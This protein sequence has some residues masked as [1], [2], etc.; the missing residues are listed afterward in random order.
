MKKVSILIA[1]VLI[2]SV[3]LCACGDNSIVGTW[4]GEDSGV[5]VSFSFNDD[6]TGNLSIA[7]G[8]ITAGFTYADEGG[9]LV[10][11]PDENMEEYLSFHDLSYTID[12]D[13]MTLTDSDTTYTLTRSEE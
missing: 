7:G 6:G 4:V 5:T 2:C 9:N 11:T 10:L 1:I 3:L 8:L 13:T 12:G